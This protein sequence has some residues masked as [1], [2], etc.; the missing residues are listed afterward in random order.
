MSH[1]QNWLS[2]AV[3]RDYRRILPLQASG[4]DTLN[5]SYFVALGE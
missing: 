3:W 1:L 2:L 4:L 5:A